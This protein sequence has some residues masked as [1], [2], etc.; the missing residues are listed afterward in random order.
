MASFPTFNPNL[1]QGKTAEKERQKLSDE[2][3]LGRVAPLFNRSISG[4]YP[5][6]STYKPVT[7][8]AAMQSG[9]ANPG[10]LI[11]CPGSLTVDGQR[12]LNFEYF[13][14]SSMALPQALTESCDTYFYQLG[15]RLYDATPK[16]GSR[17][18]A[19]AL[20]PAPRLRAVRR[21]STSAASP[22]AC[23]RTSSTSART[24]RPAT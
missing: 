14:N 12:Y 24:H 13:S 1:L 11:G 10:D 17:R 8:I 2:K 21:A 6:G 3:G 22:R 23:C 20:G 5:P 9:L 16:D 18:A 19:A 15:K 7:A 4:R